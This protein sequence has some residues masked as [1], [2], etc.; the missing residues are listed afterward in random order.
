MPCPSAP[1]DCERAEP[2]RT[3]WF[4]PSA[5][6]TSATESIE[7]GTWFYSFPYAVPFD[8]PWNTKTH[9]RTSL[10]PSLPLQISQVDTQPTATSPCQQPP[11][12]HFSQPCA[13]H[14]TSPVKPSCLG[15]DGHRRPRHG[16]AYGGEDV[17]D[18]QR[19]ASES[20]VLPQGLTTPFNDTATRMFLRFCFFRSSEVQR[21]EGIYWSWLPCVFI[22]VNV[23]HLS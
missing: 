13:T 5:Q 1:K 20:V 4:L 9:A 3:V 21:H 2:R 14:T 7:L 17:T 6:E 23:S 15:S 11:D 12:R 22:H 8:K 16:V 18:R 19:G 10:V